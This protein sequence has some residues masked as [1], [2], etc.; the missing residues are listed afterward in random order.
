MKRGDL[1]RHLRRYGCAGHPAPDPLTYAS[2]KHLWLLL[3]V[4]LLA[5]LA[6]TA[7]GGD[8]SGDGEGDG[9]GTAAP[10]TDGDGNGGGSGTPEDETYFDQLTAALEDLAGE[11]A[12]LQEFRAGAFDA[13]LADEERAANAE[14]FAERYEAFARNAYDIL[15]SITPSDAAA[16][17]HADLL[18]GMNDLA[19]F[20][21]DLASALED[22]PVTTENDFRNLFFEL[23][24]Q[25]LELRV[26]DACFDLQ[27]IASNLEMET[28]ILCPR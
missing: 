25:S 8:D 16:A 11:S 24:G 21:I 19:V 5:L 6:A 10:T 23:D 3:A 12:A 14:E 15:S 20:A 4:P 28:E 17:Q 18:D 2:V 22:T 13:G 7:C 9:N 1:L 27:T 26:R